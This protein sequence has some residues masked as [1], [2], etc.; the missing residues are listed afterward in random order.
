M[1]ALDGVLADRAQHS[2]FTAVPLSTSTWNPWSIAGRQNA[3]VL[4]EQSPTN[5]L[6]DY[7][8]LI[9]HSE[10]AG[11]TDKGPWEPTPISSAP[12]NLRRTPVHGSDVTDLRKARRQQEIYLKD[13]SKLYL[14]ELE[15]RAKIRQQRV[16]TSRHDPTQSYRKSLAAI[17]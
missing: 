8:L 9:K 13:C 11:R 4:S 7:H 14:S 1:N 10:T 5:S 16:S 12:G 6:N 17:R 15:C 2:G 3:S